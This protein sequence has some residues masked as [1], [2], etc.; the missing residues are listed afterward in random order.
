[1]PRI[2]T[3]LLPLRLFSYIIK[4]VNKKYSAYP[5]SVIPDPVKKDSL[6][7]LRNSPYSR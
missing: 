6:I 7:H 3:Q 2:T 5:V 1:M 4:V